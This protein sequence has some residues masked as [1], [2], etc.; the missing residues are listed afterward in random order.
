M[1]TSRLTSL[2]LLA[3]A[4]CASAPVPVAPPPNLPPLPRSSIVAVLAH[5]SEL[6]LT[7]AQVTALEAADA[8]LQQK[9][10]RLRAEGAPPPAG[11]GPGASGV[12]PGLPGSP[13]GPGV[14]PGSRLG[15]SPMNT[16]PGG[17]PANPGTA[18]P[19]ASPY[20]A[21]APGQPGGPPPGARPP[22]G[23][24]RQDPAR[25]QEA[26]DAR[27]DDA[28]TAAFLRAEPVLTG[29]QRERAREIANEYR[30][31][32]FERRALLRGR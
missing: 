1:K 20:G 21:G 24:P 19:G 29:T 11:P 9:V 10:I 32:L 13:G 14:P 5:R 3:A 31:S 25:A 4:G 17:F 28:D 6:E 7:D 22:P 30:E 8:E 12:P 18:I 26:I 16:G 15:A 27:L 2:L 23:P